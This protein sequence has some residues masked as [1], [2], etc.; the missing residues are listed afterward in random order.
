MDI[1]LSWAR[2]LR[3]RRG[4]TKAQREP[5]LPLILRRAAFGFGPAALNEILSAVKGAVLRAQ[6]RERVCFNRIDHLM[7]GGE[8]GPDPE[9]RA[10]R[11][12]VGYGNTGLQRRCRIRRDFLGDTHAERLGGAPVV[13]G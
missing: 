8:G 13:A 1:A 2:A 3:Q 12:F 11:D 9:R 6:L 4:C 5:S 10:G 7:G